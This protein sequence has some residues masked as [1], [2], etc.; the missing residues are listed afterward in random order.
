MDKKPLLLIINDDKSFQEECVE[1]LQPYAEV[2]VCG[3]NNAQ[4]ISWLGNFNLIIINADQYLVQ[5]IRKNFKGEM[6]ASSERDE[7][8]DLMMAGGCSH[9]SSKDKTIDLV[10][11]L[12]GSDLLAQPI[13]KNKSL[14]DLKPE[15]TESIL[16]FVCMVQDSRK[17]K[18]ILE[19]FEKIKAIV[20]LSDDHN[21]TNQ[22][23]K[24]KNDLIAL[25]YYQKNNKEED[26]LTCSGQLI[27]DMTELNSILN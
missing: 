17:I 4:R 1:K 7:L 13:T 6:I 26:Y 2:T 23:R 24:I 10:L 20:D 22:I 15:L 19:L 25:E 18:E 16:D 11:S 9:K 27:M 21:A 3:L 12:I 14:E 5:A 8:N